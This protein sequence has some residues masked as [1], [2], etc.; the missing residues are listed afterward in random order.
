MESMTP[1]LIPTIEPP[2]P[3]APKK[4]IGKGW[5]ALGVLVVFGAIGAIN[6]AR[7][8]AKFKTDVDTTV[9]RTLA[10]N[11]TSDGDFNEVGYVRDNCSA[12]LDMDLPGTSSTF[13]EGLSNGTVTIAKLADAYADGYYEQADSTRTLSRSTVVSACAQGLRN[14]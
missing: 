10:D 4:K 6:N 9:A 1:L 5:Y 3:A 7:D 11:V 14:G 13:R 12:A 2:P 8:E